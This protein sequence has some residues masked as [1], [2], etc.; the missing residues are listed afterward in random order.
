MATNRPPVAIVPFNVEQLPLK[1]DKCFNWGRF[2]APLIV[3]NMLVIR[4]P[5]RLPE[6]ISVS[7]LCLLIAMN[8]TI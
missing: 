1:Q 7:R 6:L 8:G 2:G 5:Q 4:S 3:E